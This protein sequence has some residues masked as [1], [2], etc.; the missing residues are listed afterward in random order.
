MVKV[1]N[2]TEQDQAVTRRRKCHDLGG[3][4]DN[5]IVGPFRVCDWVMMC[6]ESYVNFLKKEFHS[7]VQEVITS[8]LRGR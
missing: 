8:T 4:I 5:Q 6:A 2:P 3:I 1:Y 7:L